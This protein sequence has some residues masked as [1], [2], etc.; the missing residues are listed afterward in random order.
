MLQD[1]FYGELVMNSCQGPIVAILEKDAVEDFRTLNSAT[2]PAE[3]MKEL[4][5]NMQLSGITVQF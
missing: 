1:L 3:A 5:V 4:S 2:N